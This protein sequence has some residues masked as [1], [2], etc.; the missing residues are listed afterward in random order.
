MGRPIKIKIPAA[1]FYSELDAREGDLLWQI[2]L[3]L[4]TARVCS[5]R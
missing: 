1:M 3:S 4:R 5:G 2:T